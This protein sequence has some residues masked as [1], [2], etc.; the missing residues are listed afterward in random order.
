MHC[1]ILGNIVEL[2]PLDASSMRQSK[3]SP[4]IASCPLL[5]WAVVQ[6]CLQLRATVIDYRAMKINELPLHAT[7]WGHLENIILK[8]RGQTQKRTYWMLP[9][10]QFKKGHI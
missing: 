10:T 1:K 2:Y 4:D 7:V 8:E 5:R 3:M 9:F 6:K